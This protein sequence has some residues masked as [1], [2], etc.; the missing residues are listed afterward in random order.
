MNSDIVRAATREVLEAY[1]QAILRGDLA[2]ALFW[3]PYVVERLELLSGDYEDSA[4]V[5]GVDGDEP[6]GC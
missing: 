6:E 1:N 4:R 5:V 2:G 3:R